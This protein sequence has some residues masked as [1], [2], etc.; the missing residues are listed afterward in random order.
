MIYDP[1]HPIIIPRNSASHFAL[2][3]NDSHIFQCD[4]EHDYREAKV[5]IKLFYGNINYAVSDDDDDLMNL[6]SIKGSG[7]KLV[8]YKD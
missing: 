2:K 7:S 8:D 5:A 4:L 6:G 1:D 3:E